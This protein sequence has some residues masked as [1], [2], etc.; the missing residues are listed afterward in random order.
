MRRNIC[1]P[2]QTSILLVAYLGKDCRVWLVASAYNERRDEMSADQQQLV[3]F[4]SGHTMLN[5]E[6]VP[7]VQ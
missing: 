3:A 6:T 2:R 5:N 7:T 1:T 4:W